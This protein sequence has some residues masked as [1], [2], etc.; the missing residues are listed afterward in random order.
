MITGRQKQ[1]KKIKFSTMSEER[2]P[3]AQNGQERLSKEQSSN[4]TI[5]NFAR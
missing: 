1:A 3:A 2:S 4:D 5:Y